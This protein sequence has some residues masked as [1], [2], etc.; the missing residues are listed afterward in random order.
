MKEVKKLVKRFMKHFR[1]G[2]KGFTLIELLVVVA[3]LGV[4][5]AVAIPNVGKFMGKGTVEAANSEATS[6]T[7]AVMAAMADTNTP[8]LTAGGTVGPGR[9]STVKA[10]DGTTSLPVENYFTG[11]LGATYTLG[12][13]GHIASAIPVATGKY[14]DLTYTEYVGWAE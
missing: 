9:V 1:Y 11:S 14:K 8:S 5:A 13:D 12:T 3:I 7:T 4:L 6:V 2:E 10:G